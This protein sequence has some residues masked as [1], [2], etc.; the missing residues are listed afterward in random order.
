MFQTQQNLTVKDQIYPDGS[1]QSR[2][3]SSS[4]LLDTASKVGGKA[5]VRDLAPRFKQWRELVQHVNDNGFLGTMLTTVDRNRWGFITRDFENGQLFRYTTFDRRGFIGHGTYNHAEDACIALFD[6]GFRVV[7]DPNR[8]DDVATS[9][10][11][12]VEV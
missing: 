2:R 8:L 6:M 9:C 5:L 12:Y 10:H 7:D 11:W 3:C 4:N 1:F